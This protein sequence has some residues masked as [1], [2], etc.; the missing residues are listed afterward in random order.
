MPK[1]KSEERLITVLSS[2][3]KQFANKS[4][5]LRQTSSILSTALGTH[6]SLPTVCHQNGLKLAQGGEERGAQCGAD[7]TMANGCVHCDT[8]AEHSP[9][10]SKKKYAVVLYI[11]MKK[12][13]FKIAEKNHQFFGIPATPLSVHISTLPV[14]FHMECTEL[15]SK[16]QLKN[17][18]AH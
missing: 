16:I 13:G 5:P 9:A 17:L 11:L 1:V 2:A 10:N 4:K 8:L 18:I 14:N 15:R 6:P 7:S 3:F 12:T